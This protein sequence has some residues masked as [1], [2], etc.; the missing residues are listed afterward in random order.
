MRADI[1]SLGAT[2]YELLTGER[3]F[4]RD[5]LM[6][7]LMAVANEPPRP[8]HAVAPVVPQG[9]SQIVLKCLA[10]RPEDRFQT[11]EALAAALESYASWSPTPAT[12]GRRLLAGAIDSVIP[13]ILLSPLWLVLGS[14]QFYGFDQRVLFTFLAAATSLD[15]A[16]YWLCESRWGATLGKALLALTVIDATARGL[17]RAPSSCASWSSRHPQCCS[18]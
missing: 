3:P 16:Y 1:Y 14:T 6:S 4:T 10:K 12:L 15:I 18:M 9:L 17:G 11:Y 7:L 8:P 2:L 13:I 5:D